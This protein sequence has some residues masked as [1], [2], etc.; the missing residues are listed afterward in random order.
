M[1]F[2]VAR[3]RKYGDTA[4]TKKPHIVETKKQNSLELLIDLMAAD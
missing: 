2:W 1:E 4:G 3:S